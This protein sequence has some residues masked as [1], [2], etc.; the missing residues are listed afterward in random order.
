MLD[1]DLFYEKFIAL[2]EWYGKADMSENTL[3]QAIEAYYV[4]LKD[5][6]PDEALDDVMAIG[7][8]KFFP[9]ID[10]ILARWEGDPD[11]RAIDEWDAIDRYARASGR[12]VSEIGL[13]EQGVRALRSIGGL[14]IFQSDNF[15]ASRS[16]IRRDF[17]DAWRSI[18]RSIEVEKSKARILAINPS[19][20]TPTDKTLAGDTGT[21]ETA[22]FLPPST[23]EQ[24]TIESPKIEY[25]IYTDENGRPCARPKN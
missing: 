24:V 3:G 11:A 14:E 12:R 22:K 15:L 13:S 9:T 5:A 4:A 1:L 17:L 19:Q 21:G 18:R 8:Y 16:Y 23:T 25:E 7:R 20:Q 10:E 6:I 2:V